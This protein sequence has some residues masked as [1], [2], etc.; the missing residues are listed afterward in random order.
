MPI[1]VRDASARIAQKAELIT[2]FNKVGSHRLKLMTET[3]VVA[4][5]PMEVEEF[6]DGKRVD[7][8]SRMV[9][10]EQKVAIAL[11]LFIEHRG[12]KLL[13]VTSNL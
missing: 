10:G 9:T 1:N 11:I 3:N 13:F 8:G 4:E 2:P 7:L 6:L 5:N 12:M